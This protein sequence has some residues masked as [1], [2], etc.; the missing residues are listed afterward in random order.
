MIT[1]KYTPK[2]MIFFLLSTSFALTS[3]TDFDTDEYE[4]N[5]VKEF[6]Q[7]YAP[8][9]KIID[10]VLYVDWK[11][12]STINGQSL[13]LKV[14]MNYLKDG[15]NEK[16]RI[17]IIS[18]SIYGP[19]DYTRPKD[20]NKKPEING[21]EFEITESG[22]PVILNK[23]GRPLNKED[24]FRFTLLKRAYHFRP[25]VYRLTDDRGE[26]RENIFRAKDV[27]GLQNYKDLSCYDVEE[28]KEDLRLKRM[29][30]EGARLGLE[31]LAN[32]A[33]DDLTPKNCLSNERLQ[34][35]I[36]PPEVPDDESVGIFCGTTANCEIDFIYNARNISVI[37]HKNRLDVIPKWQKY[38]N[39]VI[40]TIQQFETQ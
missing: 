23:D 20:P 40:Q 19:F 14:P 7:T 21:F 28:L 29:G 12:N 3:C 30:Y 36:S 1:S 37:T 11:P 39:Q 17:G 34:F 31:L 18:D 2:R 27:N 4:N 8:E 33:A 32:K 15:I 35:W 22:Q 25:Q 24:I 38:K 16:G 10:R 9:Y 6:N 13:K 26:K 5:K